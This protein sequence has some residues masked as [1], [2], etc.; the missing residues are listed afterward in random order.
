MQERVTKKTHKAEFIALSGL[1]T[2]DEN[3]Q[4]RLQTQTQIIQTQT[5][6]A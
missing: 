6:P 5:V 1:Q 3:K 4:G 2:V